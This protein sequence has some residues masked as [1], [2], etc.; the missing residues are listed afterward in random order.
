MPIEFDFTTSIINITSPT[1]DLTVQELY[2]ACR[3][4]ENTLYEGMAYAGIVEG[5]GKEELAPG[6]YQGITMTL[7]DP[8]QI[9]Y[10]A[11]FYKATISD[12][13]IISNRPDRVVINYTAGVQV[14]L[15]QSVAST[16]VITGGAL[17][18]EEHDALLLTLNNTKNIKNAVT[19]IL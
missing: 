13:N 1:T 8:W 7:L 17:T 9:K 6:V 11:G 19:T 16:I 4:A 12:G 10:W 3:D 5:S 18:P 15:L 14:I 2:D